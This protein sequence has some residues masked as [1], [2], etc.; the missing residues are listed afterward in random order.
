[1]LD[2]AA[3]RAA[4]EGTLSSCLASF[5]EDQWCPPAIVL[6]KQEQKLEEI[7]RYAVQRTTRYAGLRALFDEIATRPADALRRFPFLAKHEMQ[8]ERA[9]LLAHPAPRRVS[10]KTTGGSTGQAVTVVKDRAAT[11]HERAAMWLGYSWFGVEMGDRVAR[12]WGAPFALRNRW[13]VRVSDALMHRIRFSAFAFTNADLE[14]YY[15]RCLRFRPDYLHGYVSMLE[16]FARFLDTRGLDLRH[17]VALK[18]I[19]ATSEVLTEPQRALMQRVFGAP[20]QVE[21]GCGEVGPIAYQCER[22]SLHIL[23]V[24]LFVEVLRPDGSPANPGE[25]GEIVI[26]DLTNQAMPIIRYR[27]GDS[28]VLGGPCACGRGLPVLARI[29]GRAYDFI[30]APDG[31][32]FHGEFFMYLFED[33]RREGLPIGQFKVIQHSADALEFLV[34]TPGMPLDVLRARILEFVM[35][36]AQG[37]RTVTVTPVA[38]IPRSASGKMQVI[39]N[40]SSR[41]DH[42]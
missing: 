30:L 42:G 37:F 11:A 29:W 20:V 7:L 4:G 15:Q 8:S 22:G 2:P 31:R 25:T 36:R 6:K 9:S 16:A 27:I 21:Y 28:G 39:E 19:V 14:R 13:V 24:N 35:A 17:R 34:V 38:E 5:K 32:R 33:L 10:E 40:R 18:S 26:T 1:V 3:L 12:F 23:T 41:S